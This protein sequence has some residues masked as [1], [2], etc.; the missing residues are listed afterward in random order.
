M[1][2]GQVMARVGW[3]GSGEGVREGAKACKRGGVRAHAWGQVRPRIVWPA[4]LGQLA[5][6]ADSIGQG[7]STRRAPGDQERDCNGRHGAGRFLALVGG[8]L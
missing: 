2:G 3:G 4:G 8:H 6:V 5:P 1:R 7:A